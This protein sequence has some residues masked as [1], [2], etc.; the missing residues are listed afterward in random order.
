MDAKRLAEEL[1]KRVPPNW[2]YQ[3]LRVDPFQ[4][5][6]HKKR[7]DEVKKVVEPVNGGKVLDIG[8]ADGTFSKVILD[9]YKDYN[10]V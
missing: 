3:S 8:C 9:E 5:F 7:F 10:L 6:W 4:R 2:Y 1:H